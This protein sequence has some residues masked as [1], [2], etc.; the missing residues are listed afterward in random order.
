[1]QTIEVIPTLD[2]SAYADNDVLFN[3]AAVTGFSPYGGWGRKL[4]HVQVVDV[5]D[6][7]QDFDLYFASGAI[8]LGTFNAAVD[9]AD[10]VLEQ[11]IG[12]VAITGYTDLINAQEATVANIGMIL[13]PDDALYI[14][15]VL[16][17][18]TPTYAADGLKIRL[19]L[20]DM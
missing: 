10:S 6:Q 20:E 2:T 9:A 14:A 8:T 13:Q 19:G 18:S 17:G 12:K 15:G 7:G 11:I 16:R 1:M 4:T 3:G 5:S